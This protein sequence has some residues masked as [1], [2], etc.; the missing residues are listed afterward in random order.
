MVWTWV[1]ACGQAKLLDQ[2]RTHQIIAATSINNDT[3]SMVTKLFLF[4]PSFFLFFGLLLFF[5]EITTF[6]FYFFDIFPLLRS[7]KEVITQNMSSNKWKTWPVEF[8][9]NW[10]KIDK[11]LVTTKRGS[12]Y[13]FLTNL[14]FSNPGKVGDGR[15]QKI[16]WSILI[17]GTSKSESVCEN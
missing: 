11:N 15:I 5:W 12:C 1:W 9:E 4:C 17:Y 2:I 14:K 10:I 8:S 13:H 6:L 7:T 16:F 3:C